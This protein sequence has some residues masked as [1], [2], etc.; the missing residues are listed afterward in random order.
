MHA[1]TC[2]ARFG[3]GKTSFHVFACVVLCCSPSFVEVAELKK[4]RSEVGKELQPECRMA[5]PQTVGIF[6]DISIDPLCL[7]FVGTYRTTYIYI[8]IWENDTSNLFSMMISFRWEWTVVIDV[9]VILGLL[10]FL[11]KLWW[12]IDKDVKRTKPYSKFGDTI[13]TFLITLCG[14]RCSGLSTGAESLQQSRPAIL[15]SESLGFGG[16]FGKSCCVC[17]SFSAIGFEHRKVT[18]LSEGEVSCWSADKSCHL[19]QRC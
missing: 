8:Y 1:S 2:L 13:R 18:C 14:T 10:W 6:K 17:Y 3:I 5:C 19:G 7:S 15:L 4:K 11:K 16:T 12:P 9:Y